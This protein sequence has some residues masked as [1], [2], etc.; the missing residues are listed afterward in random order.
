MPFSLKALIISKLLLIYP[1]NFVLTPP[2]RWL[3]I[4]LSMKALVSLFFSINL[5]INSK[6]AAIFKSVR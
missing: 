1:D 6:S 5:I 3:T 2:A 4:S